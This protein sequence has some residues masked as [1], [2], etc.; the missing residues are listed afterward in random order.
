MITG[1]VRGSYLAVFE[2]KKNLSGVLKY[3]ITL[4]IP[5]SDAAGVATIQ[6]EIDKA[7]AKGKDSLWG[8]KVPKFRYE[9]M[10][11]GDKELASGDRTG[12]EWAG[13][14]FINATSDQ[15]PGIVTRQ[16]KPLLDQSEVYS[17]CLLRADVNAFPFK[18]SGNCGVGWGL[19]NLM[20]WAPGERLD[21]RQNAED[22]FANYASG[23]DEPGEVNSEDVSSELI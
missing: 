2:P 18:N 3:S 15:P 11:D 7:V 12:K 22:A 21:G 14:F 19:N 13:H 20:L 6:A 17:G 1:I 16:G 23:D 5:K 10:R 8:G 9:P 4:L